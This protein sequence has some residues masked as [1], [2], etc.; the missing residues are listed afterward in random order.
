MGGWRVGAPRFSETHLQVK[1]VWGQWNPCYVPSSEYVLSLMLIATVPC[2][3]V[4]QIKKLRLG[5]GGGGGCQV[6]SPRPHRGGLDPE[7]SAGCVLCSVYEELKVSIR[8]LSSPQ[9]TRSPPL[10]ASPAARCHSSPTFTS[11]KSP[12][13]RQLFAV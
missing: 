11:S 4:L 8:L 3:F 9:V 12:P 10:P 5:G 6:T 1:E 7:L 2:G 13:H